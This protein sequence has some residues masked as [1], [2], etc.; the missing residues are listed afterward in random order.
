[1]LFL[2]PSTQDHIK[3]VLNAIVVLVM[4]GDYQCQ[5]SADVYKLIKVIVQQ[6]NVSFGE[7]DLCF[8]FRHFPEVQIHPHAQ[9]AAEAAEAAAAQR[10]F[11]QM[12]EMLFIHQ[13][14]LGNGYLV[15]YANRLGLDICQFLQDLSKGAYVD[16]IN[17]DIEGGQISG[18]EA[19]PALFINGI[20]YLDRWTVEQIVAAI[21]A[22]ND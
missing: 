2:P 4:Y 12:H 21:V 3:G 8:I 19:A 7:N 10:Q 20:R 13:Q 22:A 11:W 16:R 1:M 17:A 14:E 6:L 18:V 5:K 15:E 9:R